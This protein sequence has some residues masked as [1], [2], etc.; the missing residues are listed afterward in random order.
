[1]KSCPVIKPEGPGGREVCT[2]GAAGR[3]E[4]KN[5]IELMWERQLGLCCLCGMPLRL[6]ESTFEHQRPK[7]MGGGFTDD[8]IEVDGIPINGAA[9]WICNGNKGSRRVEYLIQPHINTSINLEEML[10][11]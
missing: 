2:R 1:M 4:Y 3:R 7:G 6:S 11:E 10:E 5:R 9:H 8:R